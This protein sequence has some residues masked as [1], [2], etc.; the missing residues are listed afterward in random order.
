M[1]RGSS[2]SRE[3]TLSPGRRQLWRL[4]P[5]HGFVVVALLFGTLFALVTPPGFP[6]D[7]SNH[8]LRAY[9]LS[10]LRI[11]PRKSSQG[12]AASRVPLSVQAVVPLS[13]GVYQGKPLTWAEVK[14]IWSLPLEREK[15]NRV[16][17]W[18]TVPNAPVAYV[19]HA[20]GIAIARALGGGPMAL[21]FG[22]RMAS[23]LTSVLIIAVAIRTIPILKVPLTAL[24]LIP[25]SVGLYA[26]CTADALLL[27]SCWLLMALQLRWFLGLRPPGGR[28][29][30][31][32]LVVLAAIAGLCKFP[33]ALLALLPARLPGTRGRRA[34][35]AVLVF[36]AISI[37]LAVGWLKVG[38]SYVPSDVR[39]PDSS[40][41]ASPDRQMTYLRSKPHKVAWIV[42]DNMV[43]QSFGMFFNAPV[44]AAPLPLGNPTPQLLAS[45][46]ALILA[47]TEAGVPVPARVRGTCLLLF[48]L[49][50]GTIFLS[51]YFWWSPVRGP[52][53]NGVQPRYLL[54]IVP[55][56]L[57][58][59]RGA[60]AGGPLRDGRA[61]ALA[62]I[63]S[64]SLLLI[65]NLRLLRFVNATYAAIDP[66]PTACILAIGGTACCLLG[67]LWTR[68][69]AE[70]TRAWAG[71]HLRGVPALAS[72]TG[73]AKSWMA[74]PPAAEGRS[75]G[76]FGSP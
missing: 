4:G 42:V 34:I 62:V 47:A 36:A 67:W 76:R 25:S 57:L 18:Y 50:L 69:S 20:I 7:E 14:A 15:T 41:V 40:Y 71:P 46:L 3:A 35:L 31:T 48:A 32:I 66:G 23:L 16:V 68:P 2:A 75:V 38:R 72:Q 43:E 60:L 49:I 58:A 53:V 52:V 17:Q 33:Y 56:L 19:P 24:A 73:S 39:M 13:H 22:A 21:Y 59:I 55:L 10:I 29:R 51:M 6:F 30:W 26:T 44:I 70:G 11:L 9:D 54:P 61:L 28:P 5:E 8:F 27:S 65:A 37:A 1:I 45:L 74:S 63:G 64:T 12:Y